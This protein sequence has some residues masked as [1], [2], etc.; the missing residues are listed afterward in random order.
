LRS[1]VEKTISNPPTP[2]KTRV[3]QDKNTVESQ[4]NLDI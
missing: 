1:D 3:Q 2:R 4:Q